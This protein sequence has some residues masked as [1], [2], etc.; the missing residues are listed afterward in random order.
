MY[1]VFHVEFDGIVRIV[2]FRRDITMKIFKNYGTIFC[3]NSLQCR[4]RNNFVYMTCVLRRA[5]PAVVVVVV[6]YQLFQC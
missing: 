2:H 4:G 3:P 1:V 6:R 5:G